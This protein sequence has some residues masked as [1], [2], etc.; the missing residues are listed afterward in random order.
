MPK[1]HDDP[2]IRST[3]PGRNVLLYISF[4]SAGIEADKLF[5][6]YFCPGSFTPPERCQRLLQRQDET[7]PGGGPYPLTWQL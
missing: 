6:K 4:H 2:A 3:F 1:Y 7:A 5:I